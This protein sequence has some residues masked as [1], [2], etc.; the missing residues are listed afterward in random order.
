MFFIT[1]ESKK[2]PLKNNN[3]DCYSLVLKFKDKPEVYLS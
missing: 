3:F 2:K 1:V